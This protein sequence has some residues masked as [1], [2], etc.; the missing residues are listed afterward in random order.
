M[1]LTP[2]RAGCASWKVCKPT[3]PSVSAASWIPSELLRHARLAGRP[4]GRIK[5]TECLWPARR[6]RESPFHCTAGQGQQ[7]K[8]RHGSPRAEEG[9]SVSVSWAVHRTRLLLIIFA[10]VL[11]VAGLLALTS[12]APSARAS[13]SPPF[14]GAGPPKPPTL[15]Q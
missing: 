14:H 13:R 1:L 10:A 15:P 4:N 6:R 7:G 9:T 2:R 8:E 12:Q 5:I 11:A 3:C